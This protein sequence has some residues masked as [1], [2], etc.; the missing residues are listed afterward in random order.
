MSDLTKRLLDIL[1]ISTA[2]DCAAR[3]DLMAALAE[4]EGDLSACN[5][6]Q[7]ASYYCAN[8]EE[9]SN[10]LVEAWEVKTKLCSRIRKLHKEIRKLK[11]IA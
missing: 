5:V 10:K 2:K 6:L 11:G 7:K 1:L 8:H 4:H 9:L 3:L